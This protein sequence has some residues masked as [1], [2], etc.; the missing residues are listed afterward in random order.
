ML[1]NLI[2]DPG[3]HETRDIGFALGEGAFA[4]RD[5]S[6]NVLVSCNRMWHVDANAVGQVLSSFRNQNRG[7]QVQNGAEKLPQI[8]VPRSRGNG[9]IR[10]VSENEIEL[11]AFSLQEK[12]QVFTTST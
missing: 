8:A 9:H 4:A 6:Q 7:S 2:K 1:D 11:F 5:S 12:E 10:H 3:L